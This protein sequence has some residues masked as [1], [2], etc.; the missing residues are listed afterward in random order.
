MQLHLEND[1]VSRIS[2]IKVESS[3]ILSSIATRLYYN[4]NIFGRM[5]YCV[6]MAV[7]AQPLIFITS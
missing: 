1:D 6:M 5:L 2:F 7:D 3:A 4:N